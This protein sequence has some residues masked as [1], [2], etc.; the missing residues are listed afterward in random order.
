MKVTVEIEGKPSEV[1]AL[2][3]ETVKRRLFGN[4]EKES[5]KTCGDDFVSMLEKAQGVEVIPL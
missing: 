5:D 4:T 2:I 3:S 1:S